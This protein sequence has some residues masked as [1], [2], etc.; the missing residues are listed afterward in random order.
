MKFKAHTPRKRFGQNFLQDPNII[1]KIVTAA[2]PKPDEQW[3]EIGP[4][5]GALTVEL[6]SQVK[7]LTAI[8]LDRDLISPLT[9]LCAPHGELILIEAD[10]LT[11]D[12]VELAAGKK[13]RIIG[14][15][16]YNISSPLIFHLLAQLQVIDDMYF[17]LQKEVVDRL[18]ADPG[19]KVYGRL[20]IMVQYF[21]Q[22]TALFEVPPHAFFPAP[23]VTSAIVRLQPHSQI[24]YVANDLERFGAIVRQAFS[25]RRKNLRNALTGVLD[26]AGF[27][28]LQI[29][30]Q[31][32]PEQLSV[33][34][35]V[36]I[37]NFG[38]G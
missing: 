25:Y 34:D 33:E 13:L 8:E 35:F 23:Q 27:A 15:L 32:R 5:L 1:R 16:P 18:A 12:F 24:P 29:D 30:P 6:L 10:A 20:S 37:A 4:G 11:F 2:N 21:C 3:V 38:G 36:R 19:S 26:N 22:V 17:M 14:N 28:A 31:A 9:V 7:H